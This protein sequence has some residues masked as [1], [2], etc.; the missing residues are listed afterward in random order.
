MARCVAQAVERRHEGTHDLLPWL[1]YFLATV[2]R[3]YRLF[4]ERA[5]Q[6]VSPR[7]SKTVLIETAVQSFGAEFTL[8]E[9]ERACPGVSRDMVRR[10]LQALQKAGKVEC[11]GRG[12]SARWRKISPR[13]K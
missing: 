13:R 1:N 8:S 12:R 4:E 2:R 5:G 11:L 6:T 3:A 10:V 9:L 7:G